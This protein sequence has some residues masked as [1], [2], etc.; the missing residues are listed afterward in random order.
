M[1]D[2][3]FF[4]N[5][6]IIFTAIAILV[7]F[8]N[9]P[10]CSLALLLSLVCARYLTQVDAIYL[11]YHIM[12][13]C[14]LLC[15]IDFDVKTSKINILN[16]DEYEI[17]YAVAYLYL[18]RMLIGALLIYGIIGNEVGWCL[19]IACLAL[20]NTLVILGAANGYS[21]RLNRAISTYRH[22]A[23]D[24]VFQTKGI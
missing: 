21:R 24:F 18:G 20:Q 8:Y 15:I 11:H 16:H 6:M 2:T 5:A 19:S 23:L 4:A 22:R 17:N 13:F 7:G 12:F 14:S 1:F 9:K 10:R 3:H